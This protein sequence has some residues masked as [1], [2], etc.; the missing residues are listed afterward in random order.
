MLCSLRE[1]E[2]GAFIL[3]LIDGDGMIFDDDLIKRGEL[4]GEEAALSLSSSVREYARRIPALSSDF[5]IVTRIY[6]N[7]KGLGN[8]CHKAGILDT[9]STIE[10]FARGY[11]SCHRAPLSFDIGIAHSRT[12]DLLEANIYSILL[13]WAWVKTVRMKKSQVSSNQ[14]AAAFNVPRAESLQKCLSLTFTMFI[15]AI[16]SLDVHTIMAT[17]DYCKMLAIDRILSVLLYSKVFLS[18]ESSWA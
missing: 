13:M 6:A 11:V 5:K 3:V 17:Q 14:L 8:V 16:S 15:A 2:R 10:D 18:S 9:P 1:Q 4:G 12:V 7:L